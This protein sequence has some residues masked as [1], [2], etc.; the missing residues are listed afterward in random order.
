M[1]SASQMSFIPGG[2]TMIRLPSIHKLRKNL[3]ISTG[4]R[5]RFESL[6]PRHVLSVVIS[7]IMTTNVDTIADFEGDYPDWIELYNTD[8]STSVD[9]EDWFLTDD[10]ANLTK[11]RFPADAEVSAADTLLVFA[12]GKTSQAPAGEYHANFRLDEEGE[13]LAVVQPNGTT[14]EFHYS[15]NFPEQFPGISYGLLSNVGNPQDA[16]YF[17]APTPNDTNPANGFSARANAIPPSVLRGFYDAQQSVTFN[18]PPGH[19]IR[20]TL[21]GDTPSRTVGNLYS[22][23]ITVGTPGSPLQTTVLRHVAYGDD[24]V[25]SEVQ[26]NTYIYVG[27]VVTQSDT[28]AATLGYPD[29]WGLLAAGS[30]ISA[31]YG[32]DS[33]I[34]SDADYVNSIQ[35]DLKAVPSLSIV[36]DA[37]HLFDHTDGIYANTVQFGRDWERPASLEFI[38]PAGVAFN[39]NAGIRVTGNLTREVD[40]LKH[41]FR[42]LFKSEYGKDRLDLED[43]SARYDLFP[44]D[45]REEFDNLLVR[46]GSNQYSHL[47]DQFTRDSHHDMGAI[48]V[49]GEFVHLYLNGMYWGLY[50]LVEKP[51]AT[52]QAEHFDGDADD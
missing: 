9:L 36:T 19:T 30:R 11:W 51:F 49:Q 27:D 43:I 42:L 1:A 44:R 22:G 38:D 18:V 29:E 24:F 52:F 33:D 15:P 34:T 7:E 12:S 31:E 16:E 3:G 39:V 45:D 2:T 21:N 47:S 37:E 25:V 17:E 46:R 8:N 26:S 41:S 32:M 35:E 20:Y 5:L 23:P 48:A 40:K 4:S 13:Y 28:D 50:N 14:I 6:E 10:P